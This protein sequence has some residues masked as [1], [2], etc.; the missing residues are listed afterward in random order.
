M[1]YITYLSIKYLKP[2]KDKFF[3]YLSLFISIAGIAIGVATLIVTLGIMSGFHKEIKSRLATIYPHIIVSSQSLLSEE[4]FIN[5]KEIMCYSPFIYSQAI[6]KSGDKVYS[7][8]V[9]GINYDAETKVVQINKVIQWSDKTPLLKDNYI[10]LGKELAKNLSVSYNDEVVMILP[11][12]VYTPFG[13]L[14]LTEKFIIKGILFSGVYEYDNN[15]CIIDYELAVKLFSEKS[16]NRL[17]G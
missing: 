11:T 15:L 14:P 17:N 12:T 8:V 1:N 3:S 5:N 16:T 10:I 2:Q 9:K 7:V 4:I 13:N 6:L